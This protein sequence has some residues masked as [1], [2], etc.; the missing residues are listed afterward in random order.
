[1]QSVSLI[2]WFFMPIGVLIALWVLLTRVDLE[3]MRSYAIL[4]GAQH[5]LDLATWLWQHA[6]RR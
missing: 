3:S 6:R 4:R 1:M 2:G 5:G